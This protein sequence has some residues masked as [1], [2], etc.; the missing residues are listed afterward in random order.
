MP[1]YKVGV[2]SVVKSATLANPL[3][4][5]GATNTGIP[6]VGN[7]YV[8]IK[9]QLANKKTKLIFVNNSKGIGVDEKKCSIS[10]LERYFS[11]RNFRKLFSIG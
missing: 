3:R 8:G 7:P 10:Y 1:F 2:R 5:L 4:V 11:D 9:K 6:A